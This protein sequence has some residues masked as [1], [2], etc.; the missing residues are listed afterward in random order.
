MES[1]LGCRYSIL[2][3]L[4]Y[5]DPIHMTIIAKHIIKDV[6]L[7]DGLL[8]TPSINVVHEC[9]K[10]IQV[11]IDMGRLPSRIDS[12]STFTAEQWMNWTLYFSIY[13]LYGLLATDQIECWQACVLACRRLCKRSIAILTQ[14]CK[15]VGKVFGSKVVTPNMH[16]YA[17][18]FNCL[19]DLGPLHGFWLFSF[20]RYNSLLGQQ[21]T[22]N[23]SIELQLIK[24]FLG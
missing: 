24:G 3:E 18:T 5:F 20:E 4:P 14:F 17:F 19:Q 9:I 21:P 8:T 10:N 12:G 7:G 15:R 13:C 1:E 16:N 11:P 6:L 22:N 23:C 2:L